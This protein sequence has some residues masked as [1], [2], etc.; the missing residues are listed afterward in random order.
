MARAVADSRRGVPSPNPPVGAA[1]VAGG[2]L[3]GVGH[4]R[5]AGED[6]AEIMALRE[7]GDRARGATVFVTL[8][9]C[10]HHGRTAPCTEALRRA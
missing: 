8:E 9:P 4:H 7:A 5:R 2:A 1:V 3:V 10:N 6:H